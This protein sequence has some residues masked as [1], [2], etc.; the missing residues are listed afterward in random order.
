MSKLKPEIL[1]YLSKRLGLASNSV[2]QY[3]S[4]TRTKYPSLTINAAAQIFALQKGV[5]VLRMLNSDDRETLPNI[6]SEKE[7]ISVKSKKSKKDRIVNFFKYNTEEY[8]KRGHIDEVNRA[9][10][11]R[12]YTSAFILCR[13]IIENLI[14]DILKKKFPRNGELYWDDGRKR[15]LDFGKILENLYKKRTSFGADIKVIERLNQKTKPFK[16]DANDKAHSWFHLV[17]NKK[18]IDDIEID[19]IVELIKVLEKNVNIK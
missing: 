8:F 1:D 15:Y 5:T 6:D 14:I 19:T 7:K 4:H 2:Q 17:K 12:C 3:I 18:E 10:T 9:Y 11:K 16:E 13:K